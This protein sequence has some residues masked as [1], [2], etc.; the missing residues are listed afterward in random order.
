MAVFPF[1]KF[2][3]LPVSQATTGYLKWCLDEIGDDLSWWLREAIE[4]EL[5]HRGHRRQNA[6]HQTAEGLAL[7]P[8]VSRWYADLCKRWHPDRGGSNEAMRAVNDAHDRLRLAL[9]EVLAS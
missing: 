1:G 2:R 7:E 5:G 4:D 8:V 6:T 9:R 3:G